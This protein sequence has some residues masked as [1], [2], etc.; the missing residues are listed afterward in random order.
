MAFLHWMH[1]TH[2]TAVSGE[3][4]MVIITQSHI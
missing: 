3:T 1:T 2:L 4:C